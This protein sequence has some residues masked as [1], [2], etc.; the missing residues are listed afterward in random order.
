MSAVW[1]G[2]EVGWGAF[3]PTVGSDFANFPLFVE[4]K[5]RKKK[6][7]QAGWPQ[8]VINSDASRLDA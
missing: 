5:K 3:Q 6:K 7:Q 4:E 8:R 2:K 1:E